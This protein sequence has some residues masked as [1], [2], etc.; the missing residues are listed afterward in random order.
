MSVESHIQ[1]PKGIL[2]YFG[3]PDKSGRIWYLDVS[4]GNVGLAGAGKLGT[5]SGYYSDEMEKYLN[6]AIETPLMQLNAKVRC[7]LASNDNKLTLSTKSEEVLKKYILSAIARSDL[8]KRS[9]EESSLTA[10]YYDEQENHD[11]LVHFTAERFKLESIIGECSF[12]VL[13]NR[14]PRNLVVPRNCFYTAKSCGVYC[15]IA[16]I[17]PNCALAL[18]PQ[19]YPY[20]KA[21]NNEFV[22]GNIDDESAIEIMNVRALI[23]EYVFNKCF[24]AS[25]SK[26]EIEGL[27]KVLKK[28]HKLCEKQRKEVWS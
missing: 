2:K 13:I 28:H 20:K 22:I 25:N 10:F 14:T 5:L 12:G 4:N 8:A 9:F 23:Y 26:E 16:P 27:K 17:S 11:F 24:I 19:E 18:F 6:Q 21:D 1:I 15:I 7:F 3:D